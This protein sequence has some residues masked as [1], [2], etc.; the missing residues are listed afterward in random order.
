MN[1]RERG[2]EGEGEREREKEVNIPRGIV[3]QIYRGRSTLAR[4]SF[5]V[6]GNF[7]DNIIY[8]ITPHDQSSHP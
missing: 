5:R 4:R 1:E 8:K 3:S 6:K 7:P 2:R